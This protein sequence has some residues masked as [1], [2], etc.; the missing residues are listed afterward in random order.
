MVGPVRGGRAGGQD[1]GSCRGSDHRDDHRMSYR[2]ASSLA[3]R[4]K[5]PARTTMNTA[6]R[7]RPGTVSRYCNSGPPPRKWVTWPITVPVRATS[8]GLPGDQPLRRDPGEALERLQD[9]LSQTN[10]N[11]NQRRPKHPSRIRRSPEEL[12]DD[13]HDDPHTRPI[14]Q[15]RLGR[16]PATCRC[17]R[18]LPRPRQPC[19]RWRTGSRH[20]QHS[21][22]Q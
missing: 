9:Q 10:R 12:A 13:E 11:E 22:H 18:A 3:A 21:D 1:V 19:P 6:Q 8:A 14:A 15:C 7:T 2:F 4:A 16:W 5:N 20:V 17:V